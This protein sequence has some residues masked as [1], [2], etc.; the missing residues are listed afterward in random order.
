MMRYNSI[1]KV[2][3]S[4]VFFILLI[5]VFPAGIFSQAGGFPAQ[6]E[7]F[8]FAIE[9]NGRPVEIENNRLTLR[10]AP[11]TL[12]LITRG[13]VGVL[14]NCSESD[15]LYKGFLKN[16]PLSAFLDEPDFF[17]GIGEADGNPDEL[18]LIDDVSPH[19]LYYA[20]NQAHRFSSVE[21]DGNF[22]IG[23]RIISS[24]TTYRDGFEPIP[25]E[26]L[27]ADV[28]YLSMMYSEWDADYNKIELQKEALK[29]VF[30]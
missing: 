27:A 15:K 9:Q 28:L 3:L 16:K 10:K 21:F 18:F 11:F 2:K 17:M 25:I 1:M 12:V 26:E 14:V 30:K 13:P 5:G 8:S 22:V 19:Y 4:A 6:D 7:W 23:R 20:P 29:I 24:Y